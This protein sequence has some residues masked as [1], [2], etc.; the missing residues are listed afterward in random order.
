MPMAIWIFFI[1]IGVILM[2]LLN[3][4]QR[5]EKALERILSQLGE[6]LGIRMKQRQF[7]SGAALHGMFEEFEITVRKYRVLTGNSRMTLRIFI[8]YSLRLTGFFT[9]T[10]RGDIQEGQQWEHSDIRLGDREMERVLRLAS[11]DEALAAAL[12]PSNIRAALRD[13]KSRVEMLFLSNSWFYCCVAPVLRLDGDSLYEIIRQMLDVLKELDSGTSVREALIRNTLQDPLGRVRL[14]NLKLLSSRFPADEDLRSVYRKCLEDDSRRVRI[15]AAR[16][17][18]AEGLPAITRMLDDPD[19]RE[20]EALGA[21]ELLQEHRYRGAENAL[22]G[23]FARNSSEEVREGILKAFGAFGDAA[24]APFLEEKLDE[25]PGGLT[26]EVME[27][28]G[29]CGRVESVEKIYRTGKSSFNPFVRSAAARA[30]GRIQSRL[31]GV[32]AG[33]LTL[34]EISG[35]EGGLSLQEESGRGGL[36]LAGG[37]GGSDQDQ[38]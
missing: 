25:D 5:R 24:L 1:M 16:Q 2:L 12:M 22:K 33:W 28:L 10:D 27:A 32:E 23:L 31:G 17:L 35:A 30:I 11:S 8:R 20:K 15:E 4:T 26:E 6:H 34:S 3:S 36:T 38:D 7:F 37:K 13:L 18:G 9:V 29:F 19:L 14:S 21:I